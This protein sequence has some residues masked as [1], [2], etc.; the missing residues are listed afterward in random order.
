MFCEFQG[1][2]SRDL[3]SKI[4]LFTQG[5]NMDHDNFSLHFILHVNLLFIILLI[6]IC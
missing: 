4:N 3:Y 5:K 2:T 1:E 6:G